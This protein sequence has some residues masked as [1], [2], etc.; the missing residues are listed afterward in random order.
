MQFTLLSGLSASL[1]GSLC[2]V[3][4][5][6]STFRDARGRCAASYLPIGT[7]CASLLLKC[8]L[9]RLARVYASLVAC[10][11]C[12]CQ[13]THLAKMCTSLVAQVNGANAKILAFCT[14]HSSEHWSCKLCPPFPQFRCALS[15]LSLPFH[16][17][18]CSR[19]SFP[20]PHSR[21]HAPTLHCCSLPLP[22][23]ASLS[24]TPFPRPSSPWL[25]LNFFAVP[26]SAVILFNGHHTA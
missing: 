24:R 3:F 13:S 22:C 11:W 4:T 26:L 16:P 1:C 5:K 8:Q 18:L 7:A 10:G 9:A 15:S 17:L 19:N 14:I 12:K 25:S 20:F 2:V 23:C 21:F 6:V